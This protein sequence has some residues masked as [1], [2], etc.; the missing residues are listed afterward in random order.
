M[1]TKIGK[2][3]SGNGQAK[4][5]GYEKCGGRGK[6]FSG[7][8]KGEAPISLI[9]GFAS[10]PGRKGREASERKRLARVAKFF[11][12]LT[13]FG[14]EK[15]KLESFEVRV[16]KDCTARGL[17]IRSRNEMAPNIIEPALS[18]LLDNS[19]VNSKLAKLDTVLR[20]FNANRHT[21]GSTIVSNSER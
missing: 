4:D 14:G 13:T 15:F 18:G 6:N 2:Y 16:I 3:L 10:C 5:V 12:S 11:N 8:Q 20:T 17:E 1:E 9:H 19:V 7:K 21:P